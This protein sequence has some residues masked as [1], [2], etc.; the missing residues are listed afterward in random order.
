MLIEPMA[1]QGVLLGNTVAS[2]ALPEAIAKGQPRLQPTAD[3]I[4]TMMNQH[5]G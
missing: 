3:H 5:G 1:L 2:D 4:W